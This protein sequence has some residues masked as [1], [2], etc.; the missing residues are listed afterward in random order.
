MA[1]SGQYLIDYAGGA[2]F[3]T[4]GTSASA[5]L[6]ANSELIRVSCTAACRF[7]TGIGATTALATDALLTSGDALIVRIPAGHNTVAAIQ[8]SAAGNFNAVRVFED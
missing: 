8:D 1:S 3:A 5:S 6:P 7:R 2:S 4:S